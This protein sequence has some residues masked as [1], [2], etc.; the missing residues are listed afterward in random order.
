MTSEDRILLLYGKARGQTHKARFFSYVRKIATGC[1]EWQRRFDK[2]GYGFFHFVGC[3]GKLLY[4]RAHRCAW[5][6]AFGPVPADV[7]VLHECDNPKCVNPDHLFLGTRTDNHDDMVAKNRHNKFGS[8]L[9]GSQVPNAKLTEKRVVVVIRKLLAGKSQNRVAQELG[10]HSNIVS[11]IA[12]GVA[13][14]HVPRP[15]G[16]R[17]DK[18]LGRCVVDR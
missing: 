4:L 10:L 8:G 2:Q 3:Q 14:A 16:F 7:C 5:E 18:T 12:R 17:W 6:Y 15:A 1:H 13:W 11:S 9:H